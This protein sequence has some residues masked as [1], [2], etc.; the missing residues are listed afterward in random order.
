VK[1]VA[2]FAFLSDAKS[3]KRIVLGVR[4]SK[5]AHLGTCELPSIPGEIGELDGKIVYTSKGKTMRVDGLFEAIEAALGGDAKGAAKK[6]MPKLSPFERVQA[7]GDALRFSETPPHDELLEALRIA[8]SAFKWSIDDVP[9]RSEA[10]LADMKPHAL[11]V[12]MTHADA[13]IDFYAVPD[14]ASDERQREALDQCGGVFAGAVDC[15]TATEWT[16]TNR[17]MAAIGDGGGLEGDE[18]YKRYI[19]EGMQEG[20]FSDE[21]DAVSREELDESWEKW[22]KYRVKKPAD[23]DRRFTAICALTL[24]M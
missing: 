2:P 18:F 20:M 21:S 17:V 7:L 5:L 19:H 8:E 16:A 22:K 15:Q 4:G 9:K 14:S 11:V 3:K 10:E 23:L 13:I 24:A 6:P 12:W 1:W